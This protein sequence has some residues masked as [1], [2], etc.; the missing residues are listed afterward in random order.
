MVH[1]RR[2]DF[3]ERVIRRVV[4]IAKDEVLA[5]PIEGAHKKLT[6][7]GEAAEVLLSTLTQAS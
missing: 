4:Q 2:V 3:V 5:E 6:L 7:L 1:C